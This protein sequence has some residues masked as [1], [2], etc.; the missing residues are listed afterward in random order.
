MRPVLPLIA[1]ALTAPALAHQTRAPFTIAETG[2]GFAHLE[3]A[4]A[5]AGRAA[6]LRSRPS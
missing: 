3:E 5:A 1:L 6:N 4:L 2:E